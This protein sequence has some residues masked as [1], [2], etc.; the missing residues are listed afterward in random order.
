MPGTINKARYRGWGYAGM[1]ARARLRAYV[2]VVVVVVVV[3]ERENGSDE[4]HKDIAIHTARS[5][6]TTVRSRPGKRGA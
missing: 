6:D 4:S 3:E 1:Y 2:V 5:V